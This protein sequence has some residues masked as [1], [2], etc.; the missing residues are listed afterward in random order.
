MSAVS[1]PAKNAA[2]ISNPANAPNSSPKEGCDIRGKRLAP[3]PPE[4]ILEDEFRAEIRQRQYAE[5]AQGPAY[6]GAPAPAEAD[7]ADQQHAEDGQS[8]ERQHGLLRQIL[9]E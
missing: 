3:M 1:L 8:D 5:A 9:R 7:T 4:Y 6:G 2:R